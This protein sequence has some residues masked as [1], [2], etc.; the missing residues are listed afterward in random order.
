[1]ILP[2]RIRHAWITV[3]GTIAETMIEAAD[4]ELQR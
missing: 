2:Q 1:M 4:D 3:Y